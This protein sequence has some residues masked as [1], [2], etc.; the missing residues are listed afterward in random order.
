MMDDMTGKM[1][2]TIKEN[3][4]QC[5][6]QLREDANMHEPNFSLGSP[7]PEVS[8]DNAFEYTISYMFETL[9]LIHLLA[10]LS[11]TIDLLICSLS[12]ISSKTS[13][14]NKLL[15][16]SFLHQLFLR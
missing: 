9:I 4:L 12:N 13:S 2:D 14:L 6:Y 1:I 7:T 11:R 5:S 10:N 8:H 15:K 16:M 3:M